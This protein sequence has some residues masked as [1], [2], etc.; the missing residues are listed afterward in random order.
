[1]RSHVLICSDDA[2]FA[3]MLE[4]EFSMLGLS[5]R[6]VAQPDAS[7]EAEV[8]LLDLDS[9]LPPSSEKYTRMIGFTRNFS[10]AG[11]D[12][13]RQCSMILHRPFEMRMLRQEVLAG[14]SAEGLRAFPEKREAIQLPKLAPDACALLCKDERIPLSPNEYKVM[15]LLLL[16]RPDV[17]TREEI[18]SLIGESTANKAEVYICLLRGKLEPFFD[19][20]IIRTVRKKGYRLL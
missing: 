7:D 10:V 13:E 19:S 11:V 20:P 3:R 18:T 6:V 15:E 14:V 5:V 16:R 17:V 9:A 12:A 2:V 8:V 4:L 1:M